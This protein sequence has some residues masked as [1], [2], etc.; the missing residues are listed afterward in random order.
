[1]WILAITGGLGFAGT[2]VVASLYDRW[3][4]AWTSSVLAATSAL[5]HSTQ[6]KALWMA[7]QVAMFTFVGTSIYEASLR[8]YI[9]LG[10]FLATGT[11][12]VV[13]YNLGRHWKCWAF[14]PVEETYYHMTLHILP[15]VN[16]LAVFTFFPINNEAVP[17]LFLLPE[18]DCSAPAGPSLLEG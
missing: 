10:L 13:I 9:P 16:V 14:H 15:F 12:G 8:G 4:F 1:M 3:M 17:N 2:A 11:Y 6:Y 18:G 5:W 7:D